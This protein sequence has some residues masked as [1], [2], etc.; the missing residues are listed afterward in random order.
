MDDN[1]GPGQGL[2]GGNV[3]IMLTDDDQPAL[4]S[5]APAVV[6]ASASSSSSSSTNKRGGGSTP[7]GPPTSRPRQQSSGSSMISQSSSRTGGSRGGGGSSQNSYAGSV[8]GSNVDDD[9][10]DEG[11]PT[12]RPTDDTLSHQ[13]RTVSGMQSYGD[14]MQRRIG[15]G[16]SHMSDFE[17]DEF[18]MTASMAK[19]LGIDIHISHTACTSNPGMRNLTSAVH[20][21][22][23]DRDEEEEEHTSD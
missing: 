19:S 2:L 9:D 3:E 1:D 7:R 16:T 14:G 11:P 23:W 18:S 6:F 13:R 20:I 4:F 22:V 15:S 10:D 12:R 17:E 21:T 8:A 5:F